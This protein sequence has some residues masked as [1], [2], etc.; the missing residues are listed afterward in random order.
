MRWWGLCF[1]RFWPRAGLTAARLPLLL[2]LG[3]ALNLLI[4]LAPP[5]ESLVALRA[6]LLF[7]RASPILSAACLHGLRWLGD[8]LTLL[9]VQIRAGQN[10]L[11]AYPFQGILA[12]RVFGGCGLGLFGLLGQ[13]ILLPLAVALAVLAL[14]VTGVIAGR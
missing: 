3:L 9:P 14:V 10:S 8:R 1:W 11:S 12:G 5:D 7:A 4:A 6:S 2:T 13:A